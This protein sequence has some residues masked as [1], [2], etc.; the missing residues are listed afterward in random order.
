MVKDGLNPVEDGRNDASTTYRLSTSQT[1]QNGSR[2]EV[3]ASRPNTAVPHW[4]MDTVISM[5]CVMISG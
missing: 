5:R 1:L 2:T 4:C 3:A